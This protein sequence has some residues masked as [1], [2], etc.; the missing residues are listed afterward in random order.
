M[1]AVLIAVEVFVCLLL[2]SFSSQSQEIDV[3]IVICAYVRDSFCICVYRCLKPRVCPDTSDSN[4]IYNLPPFLIYNFFLPAVEIQLS[5]STVYLLL[6]L[7]LIYIQNSFKL[8]PIPPG[9]RLTR[10]QNFYTI[11]FVFGFTAF[12]QDTVLKLQFLTC[13][14]SLAFFM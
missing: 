9:E 3:C 12:S 6:G 11:L 13:V 2:G 5:L 8:I 10:L 4:L 14:F 7:L 1:V